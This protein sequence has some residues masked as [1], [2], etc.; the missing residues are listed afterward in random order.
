MD[1][2]IYVSIIVPVY[3][4][5]N[6]LVR[7]VESILR[8][9]YTNYEVLLV[10]DGSTDLS[11][12][13]CDE[14]AEKYEK[15]RSLHKENGGLSDARNYGLD[16]AKGNYVTFIDSDDYIGESYL[17]I[18]TDLVKQYDVKMASFIPK[19]VLDN[20]K[21]D[22]MESGD[23]RGC[24]KKEDAL[25][26]MCIKKYFGVSACA[27]LYA[28]E[29][30]QNIKY[31]QNR[32]YEDLLTTPYLMALCDKVAYSES[33]QYYYVQRADSITHKAVTER[34][35]SVFDGLKRLIEFADQYFPEVHDAAVCRY[36]DDSFDT[37]IH[38]LVFD[39]D[40]MGKILRIR[41][42]CINYWKEGIRNPYVSRS[43]KMQLRLLLLNVRLYRMLYRYRNETR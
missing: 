34:D 8:Q 16:Y 9:T 43:K 18:L 6:Y 32:L 38:R 7:C 39:K 25:R 27:K 28:I 13:L 23:H 24:L 20:G 21:M 11:G 2:A 41:K 4:V 15:I 10:D 29:L 35:L 17:N 12:K 22:F 19:S 26:C 1:K 42:N 40:Y 31:P 36:V 14:Y 3:N 33:I 5:E 37:I 30:F